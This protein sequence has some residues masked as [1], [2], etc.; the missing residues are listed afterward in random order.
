MELK[1]DL[2]NDKVLIFVTYEF[3]DDYHNITHAAYVVNIRTSVGD[4]LVS[5]NGDVF[6][7]V[8]PL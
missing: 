2:A 8:N 4:L 7:C 1:Y 5:T 3:G 6:A